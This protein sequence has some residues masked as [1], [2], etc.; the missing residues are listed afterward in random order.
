MEDTAAISVCLDRYAP[1]IAAKLREVRKHM[2]GHFPKGF[3]LVY[4]TY[5]ALGF[6]IAFGNRASDAVISVVGYPQWVTLFF[7]YGVSLPDPD[8]ILVGKGARARSVRLEPFSR[9]QSAPVRA[10]IEATKQ[11]YAPQFEESSDMTT[12]FKSQAATQRP[13]VPSKK[14]KPAKMLRRSEIGA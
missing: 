14:P 3:E 5:N 2:V 4:D 11:R 6:G 8:G 1:D 13:R 7:L 12:V 10:L 9:L